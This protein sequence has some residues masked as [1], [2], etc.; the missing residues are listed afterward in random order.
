MCFQDYEK[1]NPTLIIE[2]GYVRKILRRYIA[3]FCIANTE[4][5]IC[6]SLHMDAVRSRCHRLLQLRPIACN[7]SSD[8][9]FSIVLYHTYVSVTKTFIPC[10]IVQRNG[11]ISI[12]AF[13]LFQKIAFIFVH[14][15]HIYIF[16]KRYIEF[17]VKS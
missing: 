2:N 11:L 8:C 10:F 15:P 4:K 17:F 5:P 13:I 12:W 16:Y 9:E 1:P 14:F 7:R 3:L 6:I